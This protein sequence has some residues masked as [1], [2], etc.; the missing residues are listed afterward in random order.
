MYKDLIV[1]LMTPEKASKTTFLQPPC[2]CCDTSVLYG[3]GGTN[4]GSFVHCTPSPHIKPKYWGDCR[5]VTKKFIKAPYQ[6]D[7]QPDYFFS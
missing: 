3:G 7:Y 5:G 2:N 4:R 6:P 1:Q